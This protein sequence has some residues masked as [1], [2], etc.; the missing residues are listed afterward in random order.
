MTPEIDLDNLN[1]PS[2]NCDRVLE[3]VEQVILFRELSPLE[4]LVL[5]QSWLGRD[6][7]EMTQNAGYGSHYLKEVGSQLW[8]ELSEAL[9]KR[10]TKK[11]IHLILS[12]YQQNQTSQP[13]SKTPPPP[14]NQ[15]KP[16]DTVPQSVTKAEIPFP[17][18]PL[19]LNSPL[20]INRPPIE[21]QAC[22]ELH[23]PGCVIRIRAAKKMGKSSLLSRVLA[24]AT[25]LEYKTVSIDFQEADR[26]VF[27]SLDKFLRWF[28]INVSRRLNIDPLLDDYWDED[29]GSKVSC[30]IYFQGY[31]LE[32]IDRPLVLALNE[33][34][35]VF[36]YP[37]IAQDFLPMLRFWHEQAQAVDIWKTLRLVVVHSTEVYIPLRLNQSPFNIGLSIQLPLFSLEQVQELA[38]RYGLDWS[39]D[40]KTQQLMGMVGGHPYLVSIAFYYLRWGNLTL[41]EILQAA[42]T[43]AGIYSHHLRSH[44]AMLQDEPKLAAALHQ[45]VSADDSVQLEAIATYKLESMGLIEL[46][47]NRAKLSCQLYR[48]YFRQQLGFGVR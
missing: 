35:R 44:L 11:N 20:Y 27:S 16:E 13:E 25:S 14:E 29:M 33:V 34:N 2:P 4:R 15:T 31:L 19:A 17:G 7:K 6:Y 38:E 26:T 9:G 23:K 40:S 36:E 30:K 21:Q 18:E 39:D 32:Q 22:A 41:E 43:P 28:C 8:R 48:L 45:V 5:S 37:Q 1:N 3:A 12:Q 10:V 46:Q 47:G 42:P 24:H